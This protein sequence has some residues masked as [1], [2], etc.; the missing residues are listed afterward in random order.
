MFG[1]SAFG[2]GTTG[3]FGTSSSSFGTSTAAANPFGQ[4]TAFGAAAKP[5]FGAANTTFGQPAASG[6]GLFG[7]TSTTGGLFGST[8]TPATSTFGGGAFGQPNTSFGASSAFKPAGTGFG[9]TATTQAGGLFGG[10]STTQ[11]GGLFGSTQ[12]AQPSFGGTTSFG[13]GTTSFGGT[14]AFGSTAVAQDGTGHVK[15]NPTTGN[16]TMMKQGV[17]S[18]ISTRHQCI[19]CMKE[20]ENKSLE[21]LRC[22]DYLVGRK[23]GG[24]APAAGGLFG[25]PTATPAQPA[26]GGLFGATTSTGGGMF[27]QQNKSL[28]G[29]SGF[30]ATTTTAAAP[31]FGGFGSTAQTSQAGGLFGAK[32]TGFGQPT[33]AATPAFGGFGAAQTSQAGGMFGAAKPFGSVAPQPAGGLFGSSTGQTTGFGTTTNT[34]TGFG[35]GFTQPAQQPAQSIGLF[36]GAAAAKP[37]G[38]FGAP[39][40]STAPSFGGFGTNTSTQSGG[41]FGSQPAK[42]GFGG[43]G[44][45]T[46]QP[47]TG[48]G[49]FGQTS[50]GMF[51]AAKPAAPAFSFGTSS[52][53]PTSGFG[54]FG[55]N[56]G[57]SLFG[58]NQA[59]PGGLFGG[60]NT[61]GGTSSSFGT[62]TFGA[63]TTNFGGGLNF[64]GTSTAAAPAA[65]AP[66]ASSSIQQ[67]L[68]SLAASPFGENPLFKP[69][70]NDSNKRADV[71]KPTNPAAQKALTANTY[72]V[73]PHRNVKIRVKPNSSSDKTQIFEG[74][75][76]DLLSSGEMF[77]PR[78]SVKKLVLR[79][80]PAGESNTLTMSGLE[81]EAGEGV[82]NSLTVGL[83]ESVA[84][85]SKAT[86]AV[87]NN[88]ND[89]DTST[90]V[91]D[92]FAALNTRKK[93]P[94][95]ETE[96]DATPAPSPPP[97]TSSP[98]VLV[99]TGEGYYTIPP[100][101]QLTLDTEG[102]CLVTGFTVGREGYGNIHYPGTL[103]VANLNLDE[104]VFI[105]H[106]EVIVYPDDLNKP[107]LGEGLNRSA[108]ITL[109]KVWPLDKSS[110]DTI[111]SPD[112]L[113]NMSYEEKLERA[114]N[115]LGARFIEYR[116]ETGSWVFKVCSS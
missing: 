98:P 112:R 97:V 65:A 105:R 15:F 24:G 48:F 61:F 27:G 77:V 6:G 116:P 52:A 88:E 53:A 33:P 82:E 84:V 103:N 25:A 37:F 75:D 86:T 70:L 57:G 66:S 18:Q 94:V 107:P 67:Q 83:N 59:K 13:S 95:E 60:T 20:Y 113:R 62:G 111:R 39:A 114:S 78:S 40:A 99:L 35:G 43:F 69:L 89:D 100:L 7:S 5:A 29:T 108:Q 93:T 106:K 11:S 102:Q 19:T 8:S 74:L 41:L 58:G 87:I 73:S 49:G 92:S 91:D 31:A 42:T 12:P 10:T 23:G 54:G 38:G 36:G 85:A 51:G 21:E 34:T 81:G 4:N 63:G 3:G 80:M 46:T 44:T 64:G 68:L 2:S 72:K 110:G 109:D 96:R 47:S 115:R 14:N 71:L 55:T 79:S 26:A 101:G 32:P 104:T 30:G 28:F 22:E 9:A 45:T 50:G 76:D 17:Q 16:D 90:P 1:Q 56:T